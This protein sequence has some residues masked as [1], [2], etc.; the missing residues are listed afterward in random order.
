MNIKINK[1][2]KQQFY[3]LIP[4]LI[5]V[6]MPRK[7]AENVISDSTDPATTR[8]DIAPATAT[9][10]SFEGLNLPDFKPKINLLSDVLPSN[11]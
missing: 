8:P 6:V 9:G 3:L 10:M 11:A 5:N 7:R 2:D 4:P 1:R